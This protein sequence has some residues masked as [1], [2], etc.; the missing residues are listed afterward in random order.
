MDFQK[1][2][3][4]LG[5]VSL[6]Y[7][8]LA[9][10]IFLAAGA[11]FHYRPVT[12]EVASS[13]ATI[14]EIVDGMVVEQT[15]AA[16]GDQLTVVSLMPG[17]HGW[18]KDGLVHVTLTTE[19]GTVV[20]QKN[21][22]TT[23]LINK[24]YIYCDLD[25]PLNTAKGEKLLLTM[26]TEGCST[27]KGVTFYYGDTVS[28]GRFEIVQEVPED[29]CY[30]IDGVVGNG[31]LCVK[32]DGIQQLNFYKVYWWII[33]GAYAI[34]ALL[35]ARWW[36]KAK[37][38][39]NNPLVAVCTTFTRYGFLLGQLVSR[40]FKTKYKRSVLGMA[41][42]FLNPLLTMSVQYF[43]F[44]NLFKSSIPNYPVYL[45]TGI[46]FMNFFNEA[47]AMGMTS[48][49]GNSSL[50][51]KVYMPKYIYPISK[52]LSSLVNF[53]F[54]IL[55]LFLVMLVTKTPFR[56]ALILLV[57]D[58]LCIL[59]FV[60]GMGLLLSTA[61][62]FF[63]DTQFLW[64]VASM[65]WLYMTPVFY[66]EKIIP[67]KFLP[68]YHM[69]PMYQYITFARTCIIEGISPPPSS[70]LW[71][72]LTSVTVLVLGILTFKKHQDKFVLYL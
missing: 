18:I 49:T 26:T 42:S 57:F 23:D 56:P 15:L 48:I 46:V 50:I 41:W 70:Y 13:N 3:K 29:Q 36:K 24:Q 11:Q 44:S 51:K 62:T 38:G 32:L 69:N 12:D 20:L 59:V 9:A 53:G 45:L 25:Q 5:I 28:A 2:K 7:W 60:T 67:A 35:C 27:G 31:R 54:A 66:S 34:A 6:V 71:C 17:S 64:S 40:N 63:Q 65:M 58:I 30:T 22:A 33:L 43:V 68:I 4:L 52:T 10:A 47:V 14:G 37:E 39:R 61:M 21:L 55:P 8:V 72:I 19:D 16:P 1:S